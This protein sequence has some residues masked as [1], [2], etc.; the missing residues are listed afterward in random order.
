[1]QEMEKQIREILCGQ[2][3]DMQE[4]SYKT[5]FGQILESKVPEHETTEPRLQNEAVS[6]IGAGFETTRWAL[7]VSSYRI[8]ANPAVYKRLREELHSAIP[9]LRTYPRGDS[10]RN[11]RSCLRASKKVGTCNSGCNGPLPTLTAVGLRLGYGLVQ[12]S[13]RVS[14]H[15]TFQYGEYTLGPG[16]GVSSDAYHLH[17]HEDIYSDS[18]TFKPERWLG[19]PHAPSGK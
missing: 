10:C 6:V 1:M 3:V 8:I 7:T 9:I 15:S 17:H 16:T 2:N 14:R 11:Y 13:P 4:A 5:L 19:D 18:Y 12:R